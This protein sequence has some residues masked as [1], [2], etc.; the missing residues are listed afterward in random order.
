MKIIKKIL[1][2]LLIV[3]V[4]AQF[5][6]PEKNQGEVS[7]LETF[8]SETNPPDNVKQI[9]K[10]SCFDCHSDRTRYPW[11]FNVTPLNYW[12]ADH[13]NHGKGEVNFSEWANYSLKKKEHKMEELWE[14]VK[15]KEMPLDSYTWTHSE[16]NLTDDQ[17]KAVVDWA[18]TVQD[19]YKTQMNNQQ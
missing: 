16:A 14:E 2:F 6:G 15:K 18:K 9:M 17:I 4:I 7:S 5:F 10:E 3:F 8:I 12:I 1:V 13:I 19:D 11:Y